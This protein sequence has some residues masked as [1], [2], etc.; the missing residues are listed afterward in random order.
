MIKPALDEEF[1]LS[2]RAVIAHAIL[3][4]NLAFFI[5]AKR[6]VDQAM[7]VPDMAVNDGEV[8][9]FHGAGFKDF[10]QFAGG[11]RIFGQEHDTAG[12]TIQAVDQA[13][14]KAEG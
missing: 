10:A 2:R 9:L 7:V 11:C 8:F 3:D 4:G 1:S 6:N 14:P 5:P 12:F 13:R